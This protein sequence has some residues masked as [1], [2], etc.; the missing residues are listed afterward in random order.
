MPTLAK[1][2]AA[3]GLAC[4]LTVEPVIPE[5][6]GGVRATPGR[7][8]GRALGVRTFPR[9]RRRGGQLRYLRHEPQEDHGIRGPWDASEVA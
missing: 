6:E 3:L 4:V 1:L 2:S 7:N 8:L 5:S 9:S